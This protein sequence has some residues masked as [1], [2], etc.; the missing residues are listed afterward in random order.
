MRNRLTW[1]SGGVVAAAVVLSTI[2][3]AS[4]GPR[5]EGE[6]LEFRLPDLEG[7]IVEASD[8]R[9]AGKVVLVDLWGTW[10]P[11]CRSEIPTLIALQEKFRDRGL[12]I[13][14]IA[15][16]GDEA[17]AARRRLLTEFVEE[18]GINY[19]VLDGGHPDEFETAL[20]AVRGV[21]GLPVEI[22]VDRDG[23]VDAVRNS[24]GYKKR[25]ARKLEREIEALLDRR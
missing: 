23:R 14:A 20:P 11:P 6:R 1:L 19:L 22:V 3:P 2:S 12:L 24:Y 8:E 13:V 18:Q 4:A 15:F 9:F 16:E 7:Q 10:C 17:S 5:V 25:W 21:K